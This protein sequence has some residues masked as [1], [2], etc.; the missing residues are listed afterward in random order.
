VGGGIGTDIAVGANGNVWAL[1]TKKVTGGFQVVQWTGKT[2]QDK[3]WKNGTAAGVRIAVNQLGNGIW[4]NDKNEVFSWFGS[5]FTKLKFKATDVASG[6]KGQFWVLGTAKAKGGYPI[7]RYSQ[8]KLVKFGGTAVRIAGEPGGEL[9]AVNDKNVIWHHN[10]EKWIRVPGRGKDI[11]VGADGSVWMIG[12]KDAPYRWNGRKWLRYW[13]KVAAIAV[14][15]NGLPWV[16]DQ[17]KKTILA[18][19]RSISI[20]AKAIDPLLQIKW[21]ADQKAAAKAERQRIAKLAAAAEAKRKAEEAKAVAE[22]K[23]KAAAEAK[24]AQAKA[25]ANI[26]ASEA[27]AKKVAAA[28]KAAL[29]KIKG[30]KPPSG[31]ILPE[32]CGGIGQDPCELSRAWYLGKIARPKPSGTFWD[33]RKG[34]EYWKCPSNRPRRTLYAVTDKRA[35][36]TKSLWPFEKLSPAKYVAKATYPKPSGAFIDIR[37]GGQY[38]KCPTGFWR[39]LNAVTNKAACTVNIGKNCDAGNIAIAGALFKGEDITKYK[40]YKKLDCGYEKGRPCQITERIPSCN[41]KLVED[42]IDNTC[43]T[44][45]LAACLTIVR[46]VKYSIKVIGGLS[47]F[48]KKVLEIIEKMAEEV[49]YIIPGTKQAMQAGEKELLKLAGKAQDEAQKVL[50]KMTSKIKSLKNI[51]KTIGTLETAVNS[52]K[53]D[54]KALLMKDGFCTMPSK[55]RATALASL[56]GGDF[57]KSS[58]PISYSVGISA[59]PTKK[60]I[61]LG[62]GFDFVFDNKGGSAIYMTVGAGATSGGNSPMDVSLNIGI[63]PGFAYDEVAGSAISL[64]YGYDSGKNIAMSVEAAMTLNWGD[65]DN[66]VGFGGIALSFGKS[67]GDSSMDFQGTFSQTFKL[68]ELN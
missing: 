34:G 12:L 68:A 61:N 37:K 20:T 27:A 35:C 13:G 41:K 2:W 22:A 5:L 42:F 49:I 9:W 17:N 10:G 7:Y 38:W 43:I 21:I 33:P 31:F 54:L 62:V 1:S 46:T 26:A 32:F 4:V 53:D 14:D 66:P 51:Q 39:N 48:E 65:K 15:P 19:K 25:A 11:S 24:A 63:M 28:A 8:N 50:D 23:A 57:S 58:T 16:I 40:C 3:K 47:D 67:G 6:P 29:G 59:G 56:L 44:A 36:A 60:H 45:P 64:S 30:P 18:E 55:D 52:N